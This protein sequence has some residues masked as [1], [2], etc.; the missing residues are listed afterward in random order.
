MMSLNGDIRRRA[1][2]RP[3]V[4]EVL[5]RPVRTSRD[6]GA[7]IRRARHDSGLSQAELATRAGVGRPWLSEMESGK[8]TAEI[9]RILLVVSALGLGRHAGTC[10]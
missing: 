6:L 5:V 1:P 4:S 2:P 10:P 7:A 8:R 3:G 9:G